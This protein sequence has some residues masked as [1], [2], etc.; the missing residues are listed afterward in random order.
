METIKIEKV[1]DEA[2]KFGQDV[3]IRDVAYA[4]LRTF[5]DNDLMCYTV[6]FGSPG[7]DNDISCYESLDKFDWLT[8][9]FRQRSEQ[10]ERAAQGADVIAEI[11]R[12]KAEKKEE[13]PTQDITFEENKAAMIELIERTEQALSSGTIDPDKGLKTIADLRVKLNDKFKVEDKS[14]EQ[15]VIV[16]P[17]FNHICSITRKECWL[18]TKEY[19]KQHWNLIENNKQ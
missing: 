2:R 11:A 10:K 19:A 14:S 4:L 6:V 17:K 1:I 3:T 15:Y 12:R 7:K 13:Q 8:K 5:L 18:Q 16:Q 9:Y